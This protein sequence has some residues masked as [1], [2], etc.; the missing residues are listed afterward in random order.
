M[1]EINVRK[2]TFEFPK[3]LPVLPNE[4]DIRASC[5]T[6]GISFTLPYLEPYLIRTMRTALPKVTDPRVAENMRRFC[7]QEAHHYRNHAV[8]N[9]IIRTK[10]SPAVA[11][12]V[13]QIEDDLQ[14]DYMRFSREKSLR[15][16]LAYAEAFEAMTLAVTLTGFEVRREDGD[17]AWQDLLDWHGAEEV[18]HRTV[19][20]DAYQ[21][22]FGSYW[23]RVYRGV[24]SQMHY[25]SYIRRFANAV[26]RDFEHMPQGEYSGLAYKV[27]PRYLKTFSP[28]YDPSKI[29]PGD[30]VRELLRKYDARASV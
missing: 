14:A 13:R 24:R 1:D 17:P 11:A 26:Q 5:Q 27:L 25:I 30:R 9:D 2:L 19:T 23:Y 4:N 18:E 7:S 12:E 16:N 10:M 8:A 6:L 22:V 3:D 20:F 21:H 29:D 15:Y 28:W